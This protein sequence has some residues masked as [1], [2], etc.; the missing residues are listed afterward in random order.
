MATYDKG[1]QVRVTATFKTAGTLTETTA[2]ALPRLPDGAN[3]R[4]D[5]TDED[6]SE[7]GIY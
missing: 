6:G 2:T 5:P 4:P 1:D 7:D 3:K